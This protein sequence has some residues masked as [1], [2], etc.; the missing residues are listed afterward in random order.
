MNT[1]DLVLYVR[2]ADLGSITKAADQLDLTSATASAALKRLEKHL[3]FTLFIRSTRQL[4]LTK[5][6][7]R[8]LVHCRTALHHLDEG[9]SAI[10]SLEGHI[11]GELRLS[12]SSDLGRNLV[13]AWIDEIMDSHPDLSIHLILGDSLADFYLDRVDLAIRY[14][15]QEDSSML[16]FKLAS[17]DR[18]LCASPDYLSQISPPNTLQELTQHNCILL[19]RN[20]RI[21]DIW[22]F[23]DRES[24]D[25]IKVK[26]SGNRTTNDGDAARRWAVAGKGIAFKSRVDVWDDLR[27]KRLVHLLPQYESDTIELN[28]LCPSRKQVTPAVLLLRDTL[29]KKFAELS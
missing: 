15:K 24:Q 29:R 19:Q 9:M 26:V 8:F 2:T 25:R 17:I 3:G 1:Q 20:N 14:G 27:H 7:E 21:D 4:R 11:S 13:Q 23:I 22:D 16:A 28:L 18:V 10:Q 5:E 12:V 6:G